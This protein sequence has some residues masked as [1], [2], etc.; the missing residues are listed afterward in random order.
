V[1]RTLIE[2]ALA[3]PGSSVHSLR[4]A[5]IRVLAATDQQERLIEAL[6]TLARGQ[7]GLGPREKLDLAELVGE[8]VRALTADGVEVQSELEAAWTMGDP[9][10]LERLVVNLLDNAAR[11]NKPPDGSRRWIRVWTGMRAGQPVLEVVN[12]GPVIDAG[13][14]GELVEPFR[15]SDADQGSEENGQRQGL[16]LGL[17]IVAAIADAHGARLMITPRGEGGLAVGVTFPAIRAAHRS[18]APVTLR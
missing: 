13:R 5:C 16:G 8:S 6:L 15:R 9:P 10:L 7:R 12:S 1:Q 14:A 18:P 4:D 17:S 3:D 2:V 11:Y